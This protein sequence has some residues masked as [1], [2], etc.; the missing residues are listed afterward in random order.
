M[1][2]PQIYLVEPYN[3]YAPKRKKHWMEEVEEQA[4]LAKIIAEQQAIREAQANRST[5]LPPQ[6][7]PV[8]QQTAQTYTGGAGAAGGANTGGGA[9]GMPV[10][11]FWNPSGDTV[12]FDRTPMSGP[13]PITVTF[14]N[15]TTTP[16]FDSYKWNFG[17]G[18]TSTDRD[19]APHVYQTGS[20]AVSFYAASLEVTNSITGNPGGRSPDVYI[21]VSIPVV[22][23][24]FTYTT[25]SN[26]APFSASFTNASVNT[27]QTPTTTYL[28]TFEYNGVRTSSSLATPPARRIDSGSFTASLQATGSYGIASIVSRSFYAPPPTL[29]AAFTTTSIG[30]GG[31]A[32]NY[33]DPVTMSYTNN[34]VYNG[35]GTL[36]YRWE[37]GSASFWTAGTGAINGTTSSVGP[38]TVA[39]YKLGNYTASLQVTESSYGIKSKGE[40]YFQVN[41]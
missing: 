34:S 13:G 24:A 36:T 6:A 27:S 11:D 41:S 40:R 20:T 31:V 18:T 4:L 12:N 37:F 14:T 16:Q 26:V 3:A 2:I 38:H 22:T 39:D 33:M 19:P 29:T 25:S 28:W 1:N 35:H 23:A 8:S 17:D 32:N 15:L 30:F 10:W 21:R 5:T 9:G 7:P